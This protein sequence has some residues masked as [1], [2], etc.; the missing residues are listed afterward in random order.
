MSEERRKNRDKARAELASPKESLTIPQ[1]K[2]SNLA[3]LP[4][5][6]RRIFWPAIF[7]LNLLSQC[8]WYFGYA[9]RFLAI[10]VWKH[11]ST[12]STSFWRAITLVSIFYLIFDR[13]YETS[14]TISLVAS[15]PKEP[16]YFPFTITNNSH[17]FNLKD[18]RWTCNFKELIYERNNVATDNRSIFGTKSEILSGD[19]LNIPCRF[20]IVFT[21]TRLLAGTIF[22]EIEYETSIFGLFDWHRHPK[23]TRFTWAANA[24]NSQWIRGDFPS[25]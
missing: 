5:P 22:I 14:A 6:T 9:V 2:P 20:P 24:T 10:S 25:K 11:R 3:I 8:L 19:V 21:N 23:P 13:M 18:I 15:D 4:Y 7:L 12:L 16:F 1:G 17:I